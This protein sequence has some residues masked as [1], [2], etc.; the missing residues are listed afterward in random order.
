MGGRCHTTST[1]ET[2][3][4]SLEEETRKTSPGAPTNCPEQSNNHNKHKIQL[5]TWRFSLSSQ[6]TQLK[7]QPSATTQP[8]P[9]GAQTSQ[10]QG[11]AGAQTDNSLC[12]PARTLP[13]L[14]AP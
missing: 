10:A 6:L 1:K 12:Q 2:R 7:P 14:A 8:A 5:S 4:S 9:C 11:N 3:K 13:T